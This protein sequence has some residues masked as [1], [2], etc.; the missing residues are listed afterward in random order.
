MYRYN[1]SY[2]H[3]SFN[4]DSI[5]KNPSATSAKEKAKLEYISEGQCSPLDL[6]FG[7]ELGLN[8]HSK[9]GIRAYSRLIQRVT[10]HV[11]Y[12]PS[13]RNVGRERVYWEKPK[14]HI[15]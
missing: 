13:P 8:S 2:T 11:I 9:D 4:Y 6:A 7:V 3:N 5:G 14:S 12:V 15:Y 1:F 10:H